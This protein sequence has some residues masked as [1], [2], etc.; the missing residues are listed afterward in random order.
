S[1]LG[2]FVW[3][4]LKGNGVQDGG[5]EI[6]LDGVAVELLDSA[7]S[8]LVPP[9][10]TVTAGGGL[11]SFANIL[12][13]DYIVQVTPLGGRV[14]SPQD[15]AP[16]LDSDVDPLTGQTAIIN[17]PSNS[18]V[19]GVDAG[20]FTG[21]IIGDLVWVD[22]NA[23]G[24]LTTGEPGWNGVTVNLLDSTGNP[25]V[26]ARTTVTAGG[27]LYSF[28]VPAA[29]YIIEVVLPVNF[30]FTT[31]DAGNDALDS[32]VDP[33]TGR[34]AVIT[35][36][37]DDD[38]ID[39]GLIQTSIQPL[40]VTKTAIDLSPA[41]GLQQG[42]TVGWI[43]CVLNANA[44]DATN[45]N[46]TDSIDT[47][48]QTLVPNSIEYGVGTN[49]PSTTPIAGDYDVSGPTAVPD[50]NNINVVIPLLAP[51]EYGILYFEVTLDDPG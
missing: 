44:S 40:T 23:N 28:A 35:V 39:A 27:G 6:G 1:G 36:S 14:F 4:D 33:A 45:V 41:P 47:T 29:D 9:Q 31:Q 19:T 17:V 51:A 37:A 10:T 38:T 20:M 8:P 22:L 49:C 5:P 16:M 26:P 11:Y 32:D 30:T 43:V 13:G 15:V 42:D 7:G 12:P 21:L 2:G 3:E 25:F 48:S 24:L 34:T 18:S 50:T 46:I